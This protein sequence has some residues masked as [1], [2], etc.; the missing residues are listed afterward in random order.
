MYYKSAQ[1]AQHEP[2][3]SQGV[4]VMKPGTPPPPKPLSDATIQRIRE[5]AVNPKSSPAKTP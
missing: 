5:T 1:G 4:N 2:T 3:P